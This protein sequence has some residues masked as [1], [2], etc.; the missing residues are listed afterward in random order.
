MIIYNKT[1]GPVRLLGKVLPRNTNLTLDEHLLTENEL[2]QLRAA[3]SF[4]SIHC[5]PSLL[6]KPVAAPPKPATPATPEAQV[7]RL[8]P[9]Q[10]G[11]KARGGR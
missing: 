11:K 5:T 10:N 2:A 9:R 1:R 3:E 6:P 7:V 8:M 4:D